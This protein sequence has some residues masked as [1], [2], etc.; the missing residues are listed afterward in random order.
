MLSTSAHLID[1]YC[2]NDLYILIVILVS[3]GKQ[4]TDK[5]GPVKEVK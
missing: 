5:S 1:A 4:V 2:I 3:L